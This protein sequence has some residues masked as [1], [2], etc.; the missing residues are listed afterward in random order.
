MTTRT[1]VDVF[2]HKLSARFREL[3]V[4]AE[5]FNRDRAELFLKCGWILKVVDVGGNK[6]KVSLWHPTDTKVLPV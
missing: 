1:D 3:G 5:W 6:I 4:S 2:A